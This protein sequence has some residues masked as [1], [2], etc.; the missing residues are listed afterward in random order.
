M[1]SFD[2]SVLT[3][4]GLDA[5]LGVLVRVPLLPLDLDMHR[6]DET[7]AGVMAGRDFEHA[8]LTVDIAEAVAF[9]ERSGISRKQI[10][11]ASVSQS[12]GASL[13][14][15]KR[16]EASGGPL[17]GALLESPWK[18]LRDAARNHLKG[19][20]GAVAEFLARPAEAIALRRAGRIAGFSPQD[21]SPLA[22]SRELHTPIALL[23]GDA[24]SVTPIEGVRA[25]ARFHPDLTIVKGA[26]H[27]EAGGKLEGG[28]KGWAAPRLRDWGF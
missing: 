14:A 2:G 6:V 23:A 16:I 7:I 21:V 9:L 1:P 8:T 12:A 5:G 22:A 20:A 24:D 27:C 11:L 4:G 17:G 25:I 18:D 13:L 19:P 10:V 28:W 3:F 15:L 26:G